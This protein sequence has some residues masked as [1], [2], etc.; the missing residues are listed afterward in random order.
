MWKVK[1]LEKK[2]RQIAVLVRTKEV[3]HQELGAKLDQLSKKLNAYSDRISKHEKSLKEGENL[4]LGAYSSG[5]HIDLNAIEDIKQ[6]LLTEQVII[7]ACKQEHDVLAKHIAT[8]DASSKKLL[9]EI[10][11]LNDNKGE[12]YKS[13]AAR[14]Q[15][16]EEGAS[17]ESWM[18]NNIQIRGLRS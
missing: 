15:M 12:L 1:E 6:F 10:N 7:Q 17:L 5:T 4:M 16:L 14:K 9:L 2:H 18:L 13:I 8:I 3:E 11:T